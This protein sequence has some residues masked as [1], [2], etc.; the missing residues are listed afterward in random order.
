MG[1]GVPPDGSFELPCTR[2]G[3]T[4]I[5]QALETNG[6]VEVG[7]GHVVVPANG[8]GRVRIVLVAGAKLNG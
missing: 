4:I 1:Y 6:R 3:W 7:R 2:G 5:V 8:T